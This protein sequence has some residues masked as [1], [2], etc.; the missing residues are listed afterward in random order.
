MSFPFPRIII[1]QI[2]S[3]LALLSFAC[4]EKLKPSVTSTGPNKDIPSQESWNAK[5]FFS[6][7]GRITAVLRAGHI[8]IYDNRRETVLDSNITVDFF[9]EHD[10]H[11]SVLTA[12]RGNVNDVTHDFEAYENVVVTSDSGTVL[13][14]EELFWDNRRQKIHTEKFVDIKSPKEHIQGTG[15][16]SD[17]NLKNYTIKR[18]SGQAVSDQ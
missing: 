7:S 15:L 6:D 18:V 13:K 1:L 4:E 9:D 5:I 12:R 17:Q 2:V 11:T 16:E 14:T 10:H 8:A 3:V